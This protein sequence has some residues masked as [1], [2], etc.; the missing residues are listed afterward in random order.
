LDFAAVELSVLGPHLAEKFAS[1]AF[2]AALKKYFGGKLDALTLE[3]LH[4]TSASQP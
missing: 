4:G 2:D 3:R 1:G